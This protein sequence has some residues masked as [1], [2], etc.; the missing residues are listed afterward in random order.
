MSEFLLLQEVDRENQGRDQ[1]PGSWPWGEA[2]EDLGWGPCLNAHVCAHT[3]AHPT[4]QPRC[5]LS[6]VH[7]SIHNHAGEESHPVQAACPTPGQVDITEHSA[8][9]MD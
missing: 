2:L 3:Q 8:C 1:N 7:S 5:P 9:G 4:H 6:A